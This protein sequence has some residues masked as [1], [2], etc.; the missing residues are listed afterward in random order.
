MKNYL[1]KLCLFG[2]VSL[3]ATFGLFPITKADRS[4][5]HFNLH[6]VNA[7]GL[8]VSTPN[9]MSTFSFANTTP[10]RVPGAS[11]ATSGPAS[12]YPSIINVSG[13]SSPASSVVVRLVNI[14][15]TFPDDLDVLLVSPTGKKLIIMSDTGSGTDLVN[16]TITIDDTAP[17][18]LPDSTAIGAG[19]FRPAN[20]TASDAFTG[21]AA[22]YQSA[23]PIGADTMA[24]T[25]GADD[26]NGNWQLFVVDDTGGDAGNI[27]GGWELIIT[28]EGSVPVPCTLTCPSNITVGTDPDSC[29]AMV[30]Y[31]EA[32]VAGGCG[33]VSYSHPSGSA[34]PLGTTTVMVT[35]TQTDGTTQTCS[36]SVTVTDN[37][38][39]TLT[40]DVATPS[41]GPP[42][43]HS[44]ENVGLRSSV[45]DNCSVAGPTQI[46]VFSNEDD[47]AGDSQ[48]EATFSP[49]ASDIA[50]GTLRLRNER[51]GSGNGRVYLIITRA[52]DAAGSSRF[53][54]NVVTVPQSNS[55]AHQKAVNAKA[56]EAVEQCRNT[57]APPAG[58]VVIGEGPTL[59]PKQ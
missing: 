22:P 16:I 59:G 56:A 30:N 26:P 13:V 23:A 20:Y 46:A 31:P 55:T 35:A 1:R 57:G 18:A 42:F 43:N 45:S 19:A 38:G 58:Y 44:L 14:N 12:P 47:D 49:D 36:F 29:V 17:S 25:F 32:Q 48:E 28:T 9:N 33:S 52:G 24:S 39:P 3:L 5:S 27:N 50:V 54:C 10:I 2:L 51:L 6:S 41:L 4:N 11:G 40:T 8:A 15:H 7:S 37:E 34:F 21:V 53:S